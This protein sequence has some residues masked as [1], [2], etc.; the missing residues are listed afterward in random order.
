M[1]SWS[2]CGTRIVGVLGILAT[3]LKTSS[4]FSSDCWVILI[5]RAL[6][7]VGFACKAKPLLLE[8]KLLVLWWCWC[9]CW[10]CYCNIFQLHEQN[11][12]YN[13]YNSSQQ[14]RN[15]GKRLVEVTGKAKNKLYSAPL[16]LCMM[17]YL[18]PIL[19]HE[20]LDQ[21]EILDLWAKVWA[22]KSV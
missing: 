11:T 7:S 6:S 4:W 1:Q 16:W 14:W 18:I 15:T 9:W 10:C 17:L 5:I 12:S 19:C 21:I 22:S 13:T 8:G 20:V 2:V 3:F